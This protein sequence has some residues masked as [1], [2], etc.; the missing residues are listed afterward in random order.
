M[1]KAALSPEPLRAQPNHR[2]QTINAMVL[3]Y[4][5]LPSDREKGAIMELFVTFAWRLWVMNPETFIKKF[6]S[7]Q[8][9]HGPTA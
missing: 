8:N 2:Y 5:S 1:P 3:L 7:A 9:H 4:D 6:N